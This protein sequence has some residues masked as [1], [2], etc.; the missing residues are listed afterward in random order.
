MNNK[1]PAALENPL[2]YAENWGKAIDILTKKSSGTK[3]GFIDARDW[4]NIVNE[5]NHIAGMGE[6]I[7]M[8]GVELDGS[9]E[10]ASELI[11]KGFSHL[12]SIDGGQMQVDLSQL[13]VGFEAG[14]MDMQGSITRGIHAVA[15]S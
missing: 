9:L 14:A 15:Q 10:A 8:Y 4:Y 2:T 12:K 7:K 3:K 5:M 13:G 11:E 1:L 6:N